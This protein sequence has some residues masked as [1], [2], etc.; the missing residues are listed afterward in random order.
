MSTRSFSFKGLS[1][2]T[3]RVSIPV[4]EATAGLFRRSLPTVVFSLDKATGSIG[5]ESHT[6]SISDPSWCSVPRL[7]VGVDSLT[8]EFSV[9][10]LRWGYSLFLDWDWLASLISIKK[11]LDVIAPTPLVFDWH[12]KRVDLCVAWEFSTVS[13]ATDI[14]NGFKGLRFPRRHVRVYSSGV[15]WPS[16]DAL[17]KVYHKGPEMRKHGLRHDLLTVYGDSEVVQNASYRVIARAD[18]VIRFEVGLRARALGSWAMR[19]LPDFAPTGYDKAQNWTPRASDIDVGVL[20]RMEAADLMGT[21]MEHYLG[22]LSALGSCDSYT[23]VR[24][25]LIAACPRSWRAVLGFWTDCQV[26]GVDAARCSMSASTFYRYKRICSGAGVPLSGEL[27]SVPEITVMPS[28]TLGVG[29]VNICN[30]AADIW[31]R[32]IGLERAY[33]EAA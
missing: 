18:R 5:W 17:V 23:A 29:H 2:D 21:S 7:R 30:E 25:A 22:K 20:W 4:S 19:L 9:P 14:L 15:C 8:V 32:E 10:K 27:V 11:A 33:V 1:V 24:A 12:V 31:T 6:G 16:R 28:L 26:G 3:L 13:E